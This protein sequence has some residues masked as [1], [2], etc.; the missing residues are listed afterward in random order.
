MSL[1]V[2]VL[3]TTEASGEY[4]GAD[5]RLRKGDESIDSHRMQVYVNVK[6]MND[7]GLDGKTPTPV[8]AGLPANAITQAMTVVLL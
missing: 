3:G 8:G 5:L 7:T 6:V 4:S 2:V 1:L